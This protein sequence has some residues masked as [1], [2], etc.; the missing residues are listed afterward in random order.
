[1]HESHTCECRVLG[2]LFL[3]FL[4]LGLALLLVLDQRL[5]DLLVDPEIRMPLQHIPV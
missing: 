4:A 2:V 3:A 1:V 5:V